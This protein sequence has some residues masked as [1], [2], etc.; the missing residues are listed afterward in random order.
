MTQSASPI[1]MKQIKIE[2]FVPLWDNVI[3]QPFKVGERDQF[4]RPRNE[5]DKSELGVVLA[6]GQGTN[7]VDITPY[8]KNG[9][10]VLFN[11]YSST[12]IDLGKELIIRA[13]DI[14]A[15]IRQ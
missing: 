2:D 4:K 8:I 13:E 9:D 6:V 1:S 3:V 14:V 11:K 15:V 5:E 10:V 12:P 7:E